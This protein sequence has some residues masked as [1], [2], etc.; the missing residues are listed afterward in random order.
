M[1]N[2]VIEKAIEINVSVSK[3]WR[4]FTD[5]GVTRQMGGYYDTDWKIGSSFG[6]RKTGGN[7]LTCG[8][9]SQAAPNLFG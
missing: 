3:V 8:I 1:E 9:R 7:R 2:R 6:F 4:V 5:S